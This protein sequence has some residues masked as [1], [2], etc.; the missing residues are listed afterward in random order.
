MIR[1]DTQL[2]RNFVTGIV[3]VILISLCGCSTVT[4]NKLL[5]QKDTIHRIAVFFDGTASN[6]ESYTNIKKLHSL[7]TLQGAN[8]ISAIYIEGVGAKGKII[9]M[10]TG[11]GNGMRVQ[12][13]YSFLMENYRPGDKIYIFGFSRGSYSGRILASMLYYAGLPNLKNLT[14][15]NTNKIATKIYNAFK[16][17]M[18]ANERKN[19]ISETFSSLGLPATSSVSVEVLG[20]WDTVEA[21]G[22]PDY[23]VNIDNPNSRYG[24]QLCNV[25]RAFHAQSIDDDRERIFTP[26]LL[27]RPYLLADC[28][29]MQIKDVASKINEIVDEV[30][31]SGAHADIGGGYPDS[32][33]SGVS[34]NWMINKLK[35]KSINL[36]PSN[37]AVP[38][39]LLG[40]SHDPEHGFPWNVFY[41]KQSRDLRR[42]SESGIYN[43]RGGVKRLKIHKSVLKRLESAKPKEHEYLWLKKAAY[44]KCFNET[45]K[46]YQYIIDSHCFDIVE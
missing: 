24:D 3:V 36:L 12:K 45:N 23:E 39:D 5:A 28:D 44:P 46:G 9:G 20:L 8:D 2:F 11:W 7:V 14:K 40:E 17:K 31:F 19:A 38:E 30:W 27:T 4:P 43:E 41:K 25:K 15:P 10:A 26:I 1:L 37:A 21:F 34:L 18:T 33:L 42:Y 29:K 32:L 35:S 13:A 6:E 16:G 22:V